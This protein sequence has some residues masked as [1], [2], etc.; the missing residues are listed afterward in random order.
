MIERLAADMFG[1]AAATHVEPVDCPAR[2]KRRACHAS[3]V[4]GVARP[5]EPVDQNDLRHR[6]ALRTLRMD[7]HLNTRLGFVELRLNLVQAQVRRPPPVVAGDGQKMGVPK[8]GNKRLQTS[9]LQ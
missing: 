1:A 7:K 6:F 4:S 8:E 2:L 5:F 3:R 9:I